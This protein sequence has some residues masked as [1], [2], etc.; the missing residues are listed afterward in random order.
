MG[1]DTDMVGLYWTTSGPVEVHFG[2]EWSLFDFADRCAEAAKVGFSG[3]GLWHADIEHQLEDRS[4]SEMRQIFDDSGLKY[5]ELEFIMDFFLDE[6]EEARQASDKTRKLLFETAAAMDAHHIKVGNIPGTACAL[7]QVTERY[8]E[9]CADAA[10]QTG[11]KILYEFMPFDVNVNSLDTALQVV[12]GAGADNG[13]LVIDTWHMSKLGIAPD[14]LRRIPLHY[15][16]WIELS[17]GQ[18]ENMD[19]PI[20]EVINHRKLPGE[21]EFDIQGYVDACRDHGYPGPWGV[22]VL[23]EE[24]RNNPIEVIFKRAYDSTAAH[25]GA[26]MR[27]GV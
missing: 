24:L 17:D 15:L 5:L 23:S 12:E 9:L 21:G 13:G 11:A 22:E 16:G 27:G 7:S 19:D 8:G 2:R 25:V 4:L 10:R 20:D 1:Q 3:I 6:G 18:F 14:D 26:G